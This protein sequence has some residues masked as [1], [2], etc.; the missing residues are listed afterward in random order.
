MKTVCALLALLALHHGAAPS[1]AVEEVVYTD[2]A[3]EGS[4]ETFKIAFLQKEYAHSPVFARY[5]CMHTCIH[6][7]I[8]ACTR[9]YA[10]SYVL[11]TR[12]HTHTY[13]RPLVLVVCA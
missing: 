11:K 9:T 4:S 5:T 3:Q 7:C 10:H 8:H 1:A 12:A 13:I 2:D 6:T